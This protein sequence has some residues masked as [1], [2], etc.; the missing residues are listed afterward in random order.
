MA[1]LQLEFD[2]AELG[3][4]SRYS[5]KRLY[6]LLPI[7]PEVRGRLEFE[8]YPE[9]LQRMFDRIGAPVQVREVSRRSREPIYDLAE[10]NEFKKRI[11]QVITGMTRKKISP[12]S[13]LAIELIEDLTVPKGTYKGEEDG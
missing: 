12:L 8:A 7:A 10:G 11:E 4:V 9:D 3:Q 13:A 2:V 1:K 5:S 6:Q